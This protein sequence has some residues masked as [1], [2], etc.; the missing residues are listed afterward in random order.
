MHEVLHLNYKTWLWSD[1]VVVW[2]GC[3]SV[4]LYKTWSWSRGHGKLK[5]DI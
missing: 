5:N 3:I 1:G 2:Y 4:V